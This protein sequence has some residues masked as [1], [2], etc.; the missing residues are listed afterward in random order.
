MALPDLNPPSDEVKTDDVRSF[1]V[2]PG[3]FI[4]AVDGLREDEPDEPKK[5]YGSFLV[6]GPKVDELKSI[7]FYLDP[8]PSLNKVME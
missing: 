8:D 6:A 4:W 5:Y 3:F 7:I 2:T 1:Y